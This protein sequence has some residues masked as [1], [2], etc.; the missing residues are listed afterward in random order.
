[1]VKNFTDKAT[2]LI[3]NVKI[4]VLPAWCAA[5]IFGLVKTGI[6]DRNQ[7]ILHYIKKKDDRQNFY[8]FVFMFL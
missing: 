6:G 3:D 7:D 5:L 8:L 4:I 2:I 1:M